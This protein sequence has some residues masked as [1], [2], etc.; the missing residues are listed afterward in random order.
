MASL[1]I[2]LIWILKAATWASLLTCAAKAIWFRNAALIRF[3]LDEIWL[4]AYCWACAVLTCTAWI[5]EAI[6]PL[7]WVEIWA[8][9]EWHLLNPFRMTV[10]LDRC[11]SRL[12]CAGQ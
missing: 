8:R 5:A 12:T 2:W 4:L 11:P 6:A 9:L 3:A 10:F 1:T 7:I